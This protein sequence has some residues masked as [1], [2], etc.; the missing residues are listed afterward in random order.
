MQYSRERRSAGCFNAGCGGDAAGEEK[1]ARGV[2]KIPRQGVGGGGRDE[3][4]LAAAADDDDD[5]AALGMGNENGFSDWG[6]SERLLDLYFIEFF[7][8]YCVYR[9][10]STFLLI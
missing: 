1:G 5:D 6:L 9:F 7:R 10:Y 8:F 4:R 3:C 2:K